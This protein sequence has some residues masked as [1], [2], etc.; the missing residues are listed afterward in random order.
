LLQSCWRYF[1]S[2]SICTAILVATLMFMVLSLNARGFVDQNHKLLYFE[3]I[4]N[5]AKEGG[6]FDAGTSYGQIPNI[7][8]ILVTNIFDEAIYRPLVKKFTKYEQHLAYKSYENNIIIKFFVYEFIITFADLFYIAFVRL[9]IVGLR[10]QLL[11][12]FFIDIVR[13]LVAEFAIPKIKATLRKRFVKSNN[14]NNEHQVIEKQAILEINKEEYEPF[15]DYLEIVTNFGYL[16]MISSVTH[17]LPSASPSLRPSSSSRTPSSPC[18]TST[19]TCTSSSANCQQST[20]A[21]AIG[22]TSSSSSATPA[23]SL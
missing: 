18:R 15:D 20:W 17:S 9:D 7:V 5:W 8:H 12:L 14:E 2:L 3:E 11:S 6:M 19:S 4:S 23:S 13:R 21:W 16:V 1:I 10:E 22:T